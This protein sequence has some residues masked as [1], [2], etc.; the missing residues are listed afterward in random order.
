MIGREFNFGLTTA[1]TQT[2]IE[3]FAFKSRPFLSRESSVCLTDSRATGLTKL[4]H[5][6]GIG[7]LVL[8]LRS[9]VLGST[10]VVFMVFLNLWL[11]FIS[12]LSS[13]TFLSLLVFFL[14]CSNLWAATV[15]TNACSLARGI[16]NARSVVKLAARLTLGV[17]TIFHVAARVKFTFS[18]RLF[19][20]FTS[21]HGSIITVN[22][23]ISPMG[24]CR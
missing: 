5:L 12:F 6:V 20:I 8:S 21:F 13:L 14:T 2:S 9:F 7:H 10:P 19:T 3:V 23:L 18:L 1:T 4:D 22:G 24:V 16:T 11:R 15:F 17:Q